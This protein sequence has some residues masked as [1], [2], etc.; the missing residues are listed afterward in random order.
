[1]K[2]RF[3]VN[4]IFRSVCLNL[5]LQI[6]FF[7]EICI[8]ENRVTGVHAEILQRVRCRIALMALYVYDKKFAK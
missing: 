2:F 1:M 6:E 3:D 8:H 4:A 7:D 5:R